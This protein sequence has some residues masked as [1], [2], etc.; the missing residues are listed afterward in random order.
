VETDEAGQ[1]AGG[2]SE[3]SLAGTLSLT[4]PAR[5]LRAAI[6]LPGD[7]HSALLA[8][9]EIPTPISATTKRR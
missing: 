7:V 8:A 3:L 6:E 2:Y 4:A 5:G 9:G 1:R